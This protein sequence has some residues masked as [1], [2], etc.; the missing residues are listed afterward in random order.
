VLSDYRVLDLTDERGAL[1]GQLLAD[2]GAQVVRLEPPG[3]SPMRHALPG[4]LM[5][6]VYARNCQSIVVDLAS[7]TGKAQ[8]ADL[9]ARVD[10][11]VDNGDEAGAAVAQLQAR[12]PKLVQ[13]SITAFGRTGPKCDYAATDLIV[14]AASGAMAI[15]GFG[16]S[17]PLRTGAITAWSHAGVAAAGAALLALRSAD[18]T[19]RGQHVDISAQQACNL[20]ASYSLLTAYIDASRVGRTPFGGLP[21]IW[22]A[23]D[24]YVSMTLGFVGPMIGFARNLLKWMH[25]SGAITEA[26]ATLD[27][28]TYVGTLRTGGDPAP[29]QQLVAAIGEFIAART[30][31]DL[32]NGA[33]QYGALIVPVSTAHD[34]L[35]DR[36]LQD[37]NFWWQS[38]GVKL[39]GA[40]AKFSAQPLLL[41]NA[42]PALGAAAPEL[43]PR[44]LPSAPDA[45]ASQRPQPL[46]GIKVLDFTWVMA[47]PWSSRVLADY[48]ATV[49]KVE[50]G[51]RLDLVRILGPFYG[52]KFS[53]ETSASFAS[54]NAGKHSLALDPGTPEGKATVLE[55]VDWADIVMESFSP[56]AM[57]KW[58]LDYASLAARKP[59]LVM[60]STCL[61]GQTGPYAMMAGYGTM[62]AALGGLALPTGEPGRPPC[63]PFGPYTD[64]VAPRF[65]VVAL[66]AALHHRDRTGQGQH[67]DQSQAESAMHYLSV[68]VAE[69]SQSEQFPDRLGN[70][71]RTM[72]PHDAYRCAGDDQWIAIAVRN[73]ADWRKLVAE[74]G[75]TEL[76]ALRDAGVAERRAAAAIVEEQIARWTAPLNA[77][78]L[79]ARMQRLGIPAHAV[80]NALI[81]K[82]DAQLAQREHFVRTTHTQLGEVYVEGVGFRFSDMQPRVGKIPSLGGDTEWVM[83]EILGRA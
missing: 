75:T 52:D 82:D 49:I 15:T 73:D 74:I 30:K 69:A 3:G 1:C 71:D 58:G 57:K 34:L 5:W 79:E 51:T 13:V 60:L 81:V 21:L 8:L 48:G 37:R 23:K 80:A 40:F 68:A 16:D 18:R 46:A 66:L 25:E 67:I 43:R 54:I 35:S 7:T 28:A 6:Q 11:I 26:L 20:A 24:G 70:T 32:L 44:T 14:Q 72:Y 9:A 10:L 56:K 59:S 47:G 39:P 76:K 63:G 33:L 17:K 19:G 38:N 77:L 53:T 61:F 12:N 62:G 27:W 41:A 64:Y 42:A 22:P 65:S 78:E 4:E 31:Q 36:Q 2:L 55:L 50:S 45:A 83:R 29:M